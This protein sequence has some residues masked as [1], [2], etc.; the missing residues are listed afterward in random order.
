M[1]LV[2]LPVVYGFVNGLAI[3][4]FLSQLD[5]FKT[6]SGDWLTGPALY[7]LLGLVVLTM[8]IIWGL[9]RLTKAFPASLAAIIIIFLLVTAL[10]IDTK[11]VGDIASIKGGFPPFHIPELPFTLETLASRP[12]ADGTLSRW[13]GA[14]LFAAIVGHTWWIVRAARRES[15]RDPGLPKPAANGSPLLPALAMVLVGLAGLVI[16]AR[17]LVDGAVALA[18]AFG[19]PERVIGLTVVALLWLGRY[20][21][22]R[23]LMRV[24]SRSDQSPLALRS[25]ATTPATWAAAKEVPSA[26]P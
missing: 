13:E 24:E 21:L 12:A 15:R 25:I 20:W 9:P 23:R 14:L 5:Q 22:R 3:I 26:T 19:V 18:S 10:G 11:T 2:P 6:A 17:W 7:T 8:G 16:G 1:R 4:I